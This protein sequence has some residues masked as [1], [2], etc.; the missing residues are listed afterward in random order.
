MSTT[1]C[2]VGS[3]VDAAAERLERLDRVGRPLG[4]ASLTF[5]HVRAHGPVDRGEVPVQDLLGLV[6]GRVDPRALAQL[7]RGLL[8]RRP[9]AAGA[10]EQDARLLER[11]D[12]S[13]A[14]PAST[15]AGSPEM[16]SPCSAA[17][18]A[19]AQV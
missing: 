11:L 19:T 13:A 14:A 5:E 2:T 7:Q 6:R 17:I 16:S 8:R 18:A 1:G 4:R 10:D 3:E 15:A 9:V 12:A